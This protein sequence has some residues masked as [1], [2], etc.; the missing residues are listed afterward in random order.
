MLG[1]IAACGSAKLG[2][3]A[4][5]F[6]CPA[7]LTRTPAQAKTGDP[8]LLFQKLECIGKGFA[9]ARRADLSTFDSLS[10]TRRGRSFGSVYKSIDNKTKKVVAVKIIN[11]E[12]ADD[13]IEDIQQEITVLAQVRRW[14]VRISS[15]PRSATAHS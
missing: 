3:V 2:G 11:L 5:L 7:R 1:A 10:L 4:E 9:R 13:E 6:A 14:I 12:E 15:Q 8:E